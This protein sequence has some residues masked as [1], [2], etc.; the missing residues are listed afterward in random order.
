LDEFSPIILYAITRHGEHFAGNF[1]AD[2]DPA[3]VPYTIKFITD[4]NSTKGK[5]STDLAS[6]YKLRFYDFDYAA[7]DEFMAEI[8]FVF[9]E[10]GMGFPN[11]LRIE[12]ADGLYACDL[13]L[14][15]K[16]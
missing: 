8:G 9:Y 12:S 16:F 14:D 10:N 1:A 3:G 2:A 11:P 5:Y 13:V 7:G 6:Q 4:F 15:Y